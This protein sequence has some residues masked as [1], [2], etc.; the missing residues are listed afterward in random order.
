MRPQQRVV[1]DGPSGTLPLAEMGCAPVKMAASRNPGAISI[2][3]WITVSDGSGGANSS[4]GG[5]G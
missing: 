4:G 2:V 3:G 5:G 1:D